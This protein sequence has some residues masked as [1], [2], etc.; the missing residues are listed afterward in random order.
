MLKS[1]PELWDRAEP[2]P[3]TSDLVQLLDVKTPHWCILTKATHDPVCWSSKVKWVDRYLSPSA[4]SKLIIVGGPKS[5]LAS[6]G[7]V[8]IDDAFH[9]VTTWRNAGGVAFHWVEYSEDLTD[10]AALQLVDVGKLLDAE[11]ANGI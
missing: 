6:K 8:L 4:L 5:Q 9:N 3:W 11:F 2:F 10:L 1:N 7:D